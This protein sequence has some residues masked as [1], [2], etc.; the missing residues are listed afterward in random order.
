MADE[1][2]NDVTQ[3]YRFTLLTQVFWALELSL[4]VLFFLQI[5]FGDYFMAGTFGVLSLILTSVYAL[6]KKDRM[7]QAASALFVILFVIVAGL[8]WLYHGL[9]DEALLAFPALIFFS[10]MIGGRRLFLMIVTS[11]LA[12]VL[13]IGAMSSAGLH[14]NLAPPGGLESASFI[15]VILLITSYSVWLFSKDLQGTMVRLNQE[16]QR[17]KESEST[18][19]ALAR[20]DALTELPNRT[21]AGER[22]AH[23]LGV[24]KRNDRLLC[25][26]F[27]DLDDFKSINDSHG[28]QTGDEVLKATAQRL[29]AAVRS[30]DCVARLGG[31]EFLVILESVRDATQITGVAEK[32]LKEIK[33]PLQRNGADLNIT[34]SIGIAIAPNDGEDFDTICRLADIAM[35]HTK[36]AGR[37]NFHFFDEQMSQRVQDR[38][39]ILTHLHEAVNKEQFELYFQPKIDLRSNRVIGAESLIR[40]NHPT[41]GFMQPVDFISIA[42][43]SGLIVDIGAWVVVQSC[44]A[45]KRW[46]TLMP[47]DFS[48]AANISSMQFNRGDFLAMVEKALKT[49]GLAPRNLELE[50]T[51][52]LLIESSDNIHSS[53]ES[54]RDLGVNLSI[55]DF[56]TGYSNLGYLKSFDVSVLKID[57]SFISKI[58]TSE[59]DRIIVEAILQVA[60]QLKL[61]VVAEGVESKELA[62]A[63]LTLGCDMAQGYYWS[64]PLNA[65]DFENFLKEN[66]PEATTQHS[67]YSPASSPPLPELSA[68]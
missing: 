26:M 44:I 25:L 12:V 67:S 1:F 48:V 45:C 16:I 37:N 2:D 63:L 35:Y 52:T 29:I 59:Y 30:T 50:L 61:K 62:D 5:G 38:M 10:A 6:L 66:L 4:L 51:E 57:R 34:A 42:E 49:S 47:G 56:G 18:I 31:D 22:F 27:L 20:L 15:V 36:N 17:V 19:R 43:E 64:E 46:Q 68:E 33:R 13:F 32:I 28:H 7:S 9:R 58:L 65:R 8:M 11:C 54:L 53:L 55:D 23:A 3:A 14:T 41:L 60:S 39:T 21:A 40:W 24:S